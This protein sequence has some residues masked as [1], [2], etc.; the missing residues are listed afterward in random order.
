MRK[1]V[2]CVLALLASA[3][4]ASAAP[5]CFTA[6]EFGNWVAPDTKTIFL[7]VGAS[8]YYRVDL[9]H[10]CTPLKWPDARLITRFRG[11]GLVC[12]AID[13]DIRASEGPG[14][15]PEPCFVKTLTELSPDQAAALPKKAKP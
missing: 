14:D 2:I 4:A 9:A 5:R 7:R 12:S 10:E 8:H 3:A 1:L 13:L 15:I 11:G 6:A